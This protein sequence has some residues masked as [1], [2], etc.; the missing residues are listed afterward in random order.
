MTACSNSLPKNAEKKQKE[1][2]K[3]KKNNYFWFFLFFHIECGYTLK[4]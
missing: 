2:C 1:I 3:Q 4:H